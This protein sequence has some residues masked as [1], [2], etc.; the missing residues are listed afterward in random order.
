MGLQE[1]GLDLAAEVPAGAAAEQDVDRGEGVVDGRD[2]HAVEGEDEAGER[3]GRVLRERDLVGG[4]VQVRERRGRE[5]ELRH[6]RPRVDREGTTRGGEV[7]ARGHHGLELGS[8]DGVGGDEDDGAHALARERADLRVASV[9]ELVCDDAAELVGLRGDVEHVRAGQHEVGG[10]DVPARPPAEEQRV[11]EH[12]QRHL[13]RDH[14]GSA[15]ERVVHGGEAEEP[16]AAGAAEAEELGLRHG[17]VRHLVRQLVSDLG[18]QV[19]RRGGRDAAATQTHEGGLGAGRCGGLH[20]VWGALHP[21]RRAL[22]EARS[23]RRGA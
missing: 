4:A 18:R 17:A 10:R 13:E 2:V 22:V 14:L 6:G 5:E 16:V 20:P 8:H 19:G 7:G 23:V 11:G 15:A 1:V 21:D 9:V 12:C 3:E